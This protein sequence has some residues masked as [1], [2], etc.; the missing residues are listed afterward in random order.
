MPGCG[1]LPKGSLKPLSRRAT[2]IDAV[3]LV[4]FILS[5][6]VGPV[7]LAQGQP[8][9]ATVVERGRQLVKRNCG[10]CHATG[11]KDSSVFPRAPAFRDLHERYPIASLGEALAEGLVTGHPAMPEFRFAPH[12]IAEILAYFESIQ[13]RTRAI[14][15]SIPPAVHGPGQ[16]LRLGGR[17]RREVSSLS[18]CGEINASG[19]TT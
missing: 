3:V 11:L 14:Q 1:A 19:R 15:N 7:A 12:Q 16:P 2:H 9:N 18:P 10:M 5:T 6:G 13:V 4:A 17:A 8:G